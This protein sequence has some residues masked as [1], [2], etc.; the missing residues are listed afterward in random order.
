MVLLR[1]EHGL[2]QGGSRGDGGDGGKGWD[3]ACIS[4]MKTVASADGLR[5]STE[6]QDSEVPTMPWRQATRKMGGFINRMRTTGVRLKGRK[7]SGAYTDLLSFRR[8]ENML[9]PLAGYFSLA[10]QPLSRGITF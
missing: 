9:F 8:Y 4:S 7:Q 10:T 1:D 3:P 5:V 2:A 6:K